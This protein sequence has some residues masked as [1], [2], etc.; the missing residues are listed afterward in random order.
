M[1]CTRGI[2]ERLN[3][4]GH[5]ILAYARPMISGLQ[6]AP[7]LLTGCINVSHSLS[8]LGNSILNILW[9]ACRT[10]EEERDELEELIQ[11]LNL[12]GAVRHEED[13]LH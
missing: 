8:Y 11:D 1:T 6:I 9:V 13:F 3:T 12:H 5:N 4:A 7:R 10:Q 2:C